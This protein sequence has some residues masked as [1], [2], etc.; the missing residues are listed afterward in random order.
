[1]SATVRALRI[2]LSLLGV[3]EPIRRFDAQTVSARAIL[4]APKN[5]VRAGGT[6]ERLDGLWAGAAVGFRT[7]P[8]TFAAE[9]TR[10]TVSG[11][12][13]SPAV[14]RDVGEIS[15]AARFDS[16]IGVGPELRYLTRAFRSAAGYQRW[17][18]LAVAVTGSHD[19]GSPVARATASLVFL[20]IL[21]VTAGQPRPTHG[22]GSEV[23]FSAASDRSPLAFTLG[24]RVQRFYFGPSAGRSEQFEA[25]AVSVEVRLQRR[26][27]RWG[28][29][30]HFRPAQR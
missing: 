16:H 7:G 29:P 24:Y 17:D 14:D 27:G 8:W 19:L 2:G 26:G 23:G 9:G 1:M 22:L 25:L 15:F 13:G 10:G 12:P 5:S 30:A 6:T 28:S 4:G 21:G 18:M 11:S 20:P 3:V